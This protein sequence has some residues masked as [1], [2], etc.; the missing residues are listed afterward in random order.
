MIFKL[1]QAG[2]LYLE[3]RLLILVS[4]KFMYL[5]LSSHPKGLSSMLSPPITFDK[6]QKIFVNL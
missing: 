6:K 1:E 3:L 2:F 5:V 4:G